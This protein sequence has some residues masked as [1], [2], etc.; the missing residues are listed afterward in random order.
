MTA[1]SEEKEEQKHL[2]QVLKKFNSGPAKKV[3]KC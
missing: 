2:V 1:T 3:E